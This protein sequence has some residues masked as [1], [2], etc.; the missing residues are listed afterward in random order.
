MYPDVLR[1]HIRKCKAATDKPFG[2]NV[3]LLVPG[4]EDY[5]KII[6]EEN[7][8]IVFSSAGS[9][10]TW[11]G[12][13]KKRNI[14]GNPIG[15]C[16]SFSTVTFTMFTRTTHLTNSLTAHIV[17]HCWFCSGSRCQ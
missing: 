4:V 16:F 9:P 2:V 14:K 1:E 6:M 11:T 8:P 13:L 7:V 12:E 17:L 15:F 3:P 5:M 10:K